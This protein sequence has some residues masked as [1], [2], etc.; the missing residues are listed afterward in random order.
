[1]TND[2]VD[3]KWKQI[4]GKN[5]EGWGVFTQDQQNKTTGKRSQFLGQLQE[6][7]GLAKDKLGKRLHGLK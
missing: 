4:Q 1:M 2:I 5:R 3:G 6:Q 7:Y